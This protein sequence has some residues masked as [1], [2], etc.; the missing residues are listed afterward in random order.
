MSIDTPQQAVRPIDEIS[1]LDLIT[2]L[3]KR[4]Q[5]FIFIGKKNE[6]DGENS[7]W[8]YNGDLSIC[9]GLCHQLAFKIQKDQQEEIK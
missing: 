7:F 8:G 4:C 1:T 5:P 9:Y 2:E 6:E 3:E